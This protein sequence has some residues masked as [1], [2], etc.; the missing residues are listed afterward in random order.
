MVAC[1]TEQVHQKSIRARPGRRS[2]QEASRDEEKWVEGIS[3]KRGVALIQSTLND[4]RDPLPQPLAPA[5]QGID[6]ACMGAG[7]VPERCYSTSPIF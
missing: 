3:D 4:A 1:Q 7:V 2:A 6:E 5:R